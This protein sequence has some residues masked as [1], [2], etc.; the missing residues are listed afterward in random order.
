VTKAT[1]KNLEFDMVISFLVFERGNDALIQKKV[2]AIPWNRW[3]RS[4]TKIRTRQ[5]GIS[6]T[7]KADHAGNS[8][9]SC[10][11]VTYSDEINIKLQVQ[12]HVE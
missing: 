6:C 5:P 10:H 9:E 1:N 12:K 3:T 4:V 8:S 2:H 7:L 11:G